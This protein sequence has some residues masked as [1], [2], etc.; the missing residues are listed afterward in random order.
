MGS[1]T[2]V[3][4]PCGWGCR[5]RVVHRHRQSE[6]CDEEDGI[7]LMGCVAPEAP[8]FRWIL[9]HH[10]DRSC[11]I[12]LGQAF[13]VGGQRLGS[14][15]K[16]RAERHTWRSIHLIAA[17]QSSMHTTPIQEG[18]RMGR[19]LVSSWERKHTVKRGRQLAI[20]ADNAARNREFWYIQFF[21]FFVILILREF[22]QRRNKS[23][24]AHGGQP[25]PR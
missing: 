5:C 24:R 9:E 21:G 20:G 16:K 6:W 19:W 18:V 15:M 3:E 25:A 7:K 13:R 4:A 10:L 12:Q 1:R 2:S 14:P 17:S 11:T 8:G 23:A 22:Y